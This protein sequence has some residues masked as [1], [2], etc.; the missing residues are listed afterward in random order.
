MDIISARY[1]VMMG[2]RLGSRWRMTTQSFLKRNGKAVW[3]PSTEQGSTTAKY[4]DFQIDFKAGTITMVGSNQALQHFI[5]DGRKRSAVNNEKDAGKAAVGPVNQS[6]FQPPRAVVLP[7][8]PGGNNARI[9]K[10]IEELRKRQ[11]EEAARARAAAERAVREVQRQRLE[12]LRKRGVV[13]R[14]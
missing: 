14:P 3:D 4:H 1:N 12:R 8:A 6:G 9:I 11:Q 13:P 2:P 7:V 10:Q 5:D